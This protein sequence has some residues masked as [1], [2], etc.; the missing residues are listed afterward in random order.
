MSSSE[1][2]EA[3]EDKYGA[4]KTYLSTLSS[5]AN[6]TDNLPVIHVKVPQ[7]SN[8]YDCGLMVLHYAILFITCQNKRALARDLIDGKKE[9]WLGVTREEVSAFL[10]DLRKSVRDAVARQIADLKPL[11]AD[12]SDE[13]KTTVERITSYGINFK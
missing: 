13:S 2:P 5:H 9:N 3:I 11:T 1:K 4:I 12:E 8:D 7:Q 10:Y 6:T